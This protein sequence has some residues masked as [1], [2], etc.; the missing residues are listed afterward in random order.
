MTEREK[1]HSGEIYWPSDDSIMVEQLSY[2]DLMDAYNNTP[3]AAAERAGANAANTVCG[4]WRELL[5]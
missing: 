4:S 3:P 1:I 5:Y 2:L